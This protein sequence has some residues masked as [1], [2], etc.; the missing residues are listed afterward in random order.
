MTTSTT[1]AVGSEVSARPQLRKRGRLERGQRRAGWMMLLPALLHSS[2]FLAV[3]SVAAIILGFTS[4]SFLGASSWV[5]LANYTEL[6]HDNQFRHAFLNTVTYTIVVVPVSMLLA[7]LVALALNQSLG[8]RGVFRTAYYIPVVTATVAVGTVW[9]WIYNPQSGLA[10]A[11]LSSL[12]LARS[13]WL[14][15]ASAALPALMVVGVWQ[16][17]GARMIVYLAALQ[18]VSRELI[19]AANLDGANAWQRFRHVT[20]PALGPAQVFVVVTAI[21][22]TFQVF[23]LV[24]VTTKG[25]P[26]DATRVLVLDVYEN[27]FQGLR[28]GY[29]SAESVV[30][31]L[32]IGVFVVLGRMTGRED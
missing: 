13:N 2:L 11:V 5:G 32:L 21:V 29:A 14:N 30:M 20:W 23:D 16:G 7:L 31:L 12:G 15:D 22:Q 25:G 27:A 26:T 8:A 28:L 9:L 10:N 17:L 3:P 18:G 24:Y 4:Y 19:E 6:F 1:Q